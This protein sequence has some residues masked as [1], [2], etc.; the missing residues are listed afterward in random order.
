MSSL[1]AKLTTPTVLL[2]IFLTL[3]Q[4]ATGIYLASGLEEPGLFSVVGFFGLLWIIGW[5]LRTD[6][7]KREFRWV[8]DMGLFLYVAWPIVLLYYL[9]KTRGA[10]G[11]LV[12]LGFVGASIA[13]A[14]IGMALYLLL[15]PVDWPTAV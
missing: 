6:S 11:L 10:R 1:F 8:Y 7:R 9:L 12:I 4:V 15:A 5:W 13:A 14:V 3:T 2:Y